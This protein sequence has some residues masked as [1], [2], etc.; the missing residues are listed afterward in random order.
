MDHTS[1]FDSIYF[2]F[3][4][5]TSG[6]YFLLSLFFLLPLLLFLARLVNRIRADRQAR[7]QKAF[8]ME[9]IER[10]HQQIETFDI[11]LGEREMR[12]NYMS[13]LKDVT[14]DFLTLSVSEYMSQIW[15]DKKVDI[16]F[17]VRRDG[18][19]DFYKFRVPIVEL[20]TKDQMTYVRVPT[21]SNLEIGQKRAFF[22]ITPTPESIRVV[23]IWILYPDQPLPR[24]TV[25]IGD[26]FLSYTLKS[27][28]KENSFSL[29]VE[30]ISGSGIAFR[31]QI[32]TDDERL[33][34]GGQILCL[35]V[36]NDSVNE[37][38]HLVNFCGVGRITNIRKIV[39]DDSNV[40][41][42]EFT[43]WAILERGNKNIN[44]F[45]QQKSAGIGPI[46]S[47]V[48]KMDIQRHKSMAGTE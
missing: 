10:A 9:Q 1:L 17:C 21:P 13:I 8:V 28:S 14:P 3:V 37:K 30:D 35:L 22:R 25:E 45:S 2:F 23:A 36:Y 47:W 19:R 11:Q 27:S 46:L 40:V 5:R 38:E 26:P 43:N 24:S 44:W 48:T 29:S 7:E 6:E 33:V 34:K 39:K 12:T 31:L 32:K 15:L 16:F 18:K 4:T 41:G 42:V 20:T